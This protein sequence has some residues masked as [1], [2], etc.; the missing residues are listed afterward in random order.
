MKLAWL[1]DIHLDHA[2]D[3]RRSRLFRE[4]RGSGADAAILTGDITNGPRLEQDLGQLADEAGM[5]LYFVLGN[6]DFYG[7][8]VAFGQIRAKSL[9]AGKSGLTYLS[10]EESPVLLSEETALIGHDGWCDGRIGRLGSV[11]LNDEIQIRDLAVLPQPLRIVRCQ[12][13][14]EDAVSHMRGQLRLALPLRKRIL[15]ATHVPPF[16]EACW[17]HDALAGETRISDNGFLP[18]FTC[19]AMGDMLAEEMSAYPEHEMLV[20]CGHSHGRGSADILPNLRVLT[21]GAEYGAP[22]IQEELVEA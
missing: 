15:V 18:Y 19:K 20:L 17:Y 4:L 11:L 6:H 22:R 12:E 7:T 2:P 1:T 9:A 16:R 13:L 21:G 10:K 3:G 5:P 8:S 14:A